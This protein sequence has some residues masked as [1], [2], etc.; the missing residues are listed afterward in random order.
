MVMKASSTFVA[1]LAD[2]SRKGMLA[3][4]ANSWLGVGL[5]VGLGVELAV[6]LGLGSGLRLG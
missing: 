3:E 2:V 6:R 5:G 4:S 1:F